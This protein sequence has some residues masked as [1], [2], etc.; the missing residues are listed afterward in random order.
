[1][2]AERARVEALRRTEIRCTP[3]T[4]IER[5]TPAVILADQFTA[6]IASRIRD[7]RSSAMA[8]DVVD[9]LKNAGAV[10]HND[11]GGDAYEISEVIASVRRHT[12]MTDEPPRRVEE[13][14]ALSLESLFPPIERGV[15]GAN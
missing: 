7:K 11:H 1:M 8:A 6:A 9:S 10:A 14:F 3:Q 5:I 4:P 13:R 2:K 15:Q 12:L